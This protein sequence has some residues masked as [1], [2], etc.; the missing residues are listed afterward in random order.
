[1]MDVVRNL[2]EA[3]LV[4]VDLSGKNANVFYELGIAHTVRCAESVLLITPTMK[5]VPFDVQSYRCIEYTLGPDGL[6]QLQDK[7]VQFV[8][9]EISSN[10]LSI[11]ISR[12]PNRRI[13]ESSWGRS[14][15]V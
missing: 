14:V 1:M 2:A 7:L 13:R 11:H 10:P 4:I 6:R 8:R 12:R 3:E 5:D 9:T 15:L